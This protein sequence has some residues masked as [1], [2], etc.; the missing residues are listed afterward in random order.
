[1]VEIKLTQGKVAFIDDADLE[2]VSI[3]KW[4]AH[5]KGR[6]TFYAIGSSKAIDGKCKTIKMHRLILGIT[7]PSVYVDHIDGNGLNNTRANLRVSSREENQRN[8]PRNKNNKSG[9]KG[10]YACKRSGKWIAKIMVDLKPVHLGR[11]DTPELAH[12]AYKAAAI[13]L[14]GNFCNT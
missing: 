1:M 12:D 3:S 14:H 13:K 4:C 5:N 7:D 8:R 9:F 11:F 6:K 10:V 2:T